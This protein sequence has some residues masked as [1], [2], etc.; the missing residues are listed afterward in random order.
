MNRFGKRTPFLSYIKKINLP[1]LGFLVLL[2]AFL[3]GVSNVSA[4][5]TSKQLESLENALH[6]SIVQCYAIEG[7]YPP[8]L[9][10]LREHY[11]LLYDEEAFFIDYSPIAS[12]LM[13][14]V[15]IISRNPEIK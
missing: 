9:D 2:I 12:N 6:R 13:P 15:T 11:G 8:S 4:T 5:T 10:Y 3:Y 1:V 7:M 14:D